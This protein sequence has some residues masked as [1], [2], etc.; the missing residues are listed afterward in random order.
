[1]RGSFTTYMTHMRD[2]LL[3]SRLASGKASVLLLGPRQVG[4]STLCRALG[5]S[6][7]VDLADEREFLSFAKDPALLQRQVATLARPALVVIDEIQRVPALLNTVQSLV[8]RAAGRL[9][10]VLTGSS[11]RKLRRGGGNLLPGRIILE[12]LHPLSVLEVD[13]PVDFDRALRLGML[14]GV[15]WG[16]DE[17]DAL[18]GTYAEVYL[19]EE[20]QAEGAAR[21]IGSYA[22]FL[23]VLAVASGQWINYSKLSSDSEIPKETIRRYVQVLED[24]LVAVRIP[25]FTPKVRTTRRVQQR[26]RVLLFD[27]GVRNALLGQHRHAPS[28]DLIGSIFEQWVI[29]QFVYLNDALRKGWRFSSYRSEGGAEVDLVIE[30]DD[31]MIGIEIKAARNL[32]TADTRGLLSLGELVP[33]SRRLRKWI[34]YRGERRQRFP[35]GVEAWPVLEA[36]EALR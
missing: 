20:I 6:L 5:A 14:P 35:N 19:R 34:L 11:A 9:R 24:T 17:A 32:S 2:R 15:Y 27:V 22:R 10:F 36:F 21:D 4:K 23:D 29:L 7:Y 30:T 33:R 31:G 16:D 12:R 25:A 13:R 1:M 3:A 8:D 28:A 18:L 26:E